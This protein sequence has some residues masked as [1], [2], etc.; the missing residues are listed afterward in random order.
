MRQR[1]SLRK[2]LFLLLILN[3]KNCREEINSHN[4]YLE[5]KNYQP[6]ANN[7]SLTK[8]T[9]HCFLLCIVGT[10]NRQKNDKIKYDTIIAVYQLG[11]N[12][13]I[14]P[15]TRTSTCIVQQLWKIII[16]SYLTLIGTIVR[17]IAQKSLDSH[18]KFLLMIAMPE[19]IETCNT[20]SKDLDKRETKFNIMTQ[21][22]NGGYITKLEDIIM[23][24]KKY[25]CDILCLQE[26]KLNDNH[27]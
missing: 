8:V 24:L 27:W 2:T 12:C 20:C 22:I 6:Y 10:L 7:I 9:Y 14:V 18:K 15:S 11:F 25:D 26:I 16:N 23:T 19:E 1:F 5:E 21:N 13:F 3:L 17:K 4:Y